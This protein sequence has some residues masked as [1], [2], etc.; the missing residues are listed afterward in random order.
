MQRIP[1]PF[2]V[3]QRDHHG[4]I[5][6]LRA[7]KRSDMDGITSVMLEDQQYKGKSEPASLR[8][9][10]SFVHPKTSDKRSP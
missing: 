1:H 2:E 10:R 6:S 8:P 4:D 7:L 3:R 5:G 9:I